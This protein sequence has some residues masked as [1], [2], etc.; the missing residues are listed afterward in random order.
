MTETSKRQTHMVNEGDSRISQYIVAAKKCDYATTQA[1]V[2]TAVANGDWGI[3][4][5][6]ITVNCMAFAQLQQAN[7]C[8]RV[9]QREARGWRNIAKGLKG[10][11]VSKDAKDKIR[12]GSQ[13]LREAEDTKEQLDGGYLELDWR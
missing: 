9:A 4:R 1:L 3:L 5:R 2:D 6:F 10:G 8:L 11:G 7:Q 13:Q 12:I